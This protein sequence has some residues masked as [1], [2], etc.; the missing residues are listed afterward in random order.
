VW[1]ERAAGLTA[2][3]SS[4][5]YAGCNGLYIYGGEAQA[6]AV[7]ALVERVAASGMPFAVKVRS[8]V[9]GLDGLLASLALH[10]HEDLPLMAVERNGFVAAPCPSELSLRTLTA[11][12][13]RLHMDLVA[14]GLG[15]PRGS[16]DLVMSDANQ[17][18]PCWASYV[19]EV[20]GALAVTGSSIAGAAHAGLIAIA[21][22]DAFRRRGY[23]AALTS[24]MVAD[25]FDAG[26]ER[27][28]LHASA[29]GYRIY[30]A[31]GFRKLEDLRVWIGGP[32]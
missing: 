26:A 5:P 23:A 27:V 7:K 28:F 32:A 14:R 20:D 10:W 8:A 9:G 2:H 21:T 24:R 15:T 31:L 1:T 6:S 4:L 29:M 25:A 11:D 17:A 13:P 12:E 22:D 19:G 3:G 30:E 18:L 16:L